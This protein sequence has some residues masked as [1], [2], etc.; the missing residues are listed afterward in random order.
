MLEDGHTVDTEP[1]P[2]GHWLH[3]HP[4]VFSSVHLTPRTIWSG[5]TTMHR[6]FELFVDILRRSRGVEALAGVVDPVAG[7]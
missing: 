3:G 7:Y 2:E 6:I 5:V 4:C 1:L